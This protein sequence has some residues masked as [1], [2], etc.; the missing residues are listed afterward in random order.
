MA[1]YRTSLQER[2]RER[3]PLDWAATETSLATTLRHLGNREQ[4]AEHLTDAVAT[5]R[6]VLLK[7][8]SDQQVEAAGSPI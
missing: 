2:T 5:Y 7:Y 3:A 6:A 4:G 1:A 8:P